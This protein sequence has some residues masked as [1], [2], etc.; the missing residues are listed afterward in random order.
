MRVQTGAEMVQQMRDLRYEVA[1]PDYCAGH[2]VVVAAEIFCG[3]VESD[4][5]PERT[6]LEG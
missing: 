3:A 1:T 2:D 6:R 5:K 4:I